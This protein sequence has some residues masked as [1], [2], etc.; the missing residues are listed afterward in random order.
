V[1]V[2]GTPPTAEGI[3]R[4]CR[5]VAE[6]IDIEIATI[7]RRPFESRRIV[8]LFLHVA[9]GTGE[10]QERRGNDVH[11]LSIGDERLGLGRANEAGDMGLARIRCSAPSTANM[12][13][14]ATLA[15]LCS[16]APGSGTDPGSHRPRIDDGNS[17]A[18]DDMGPGPARQGGRRCLPLRASFARRFRRSFAEGNRIGWRRSRPSAQFRGHRHCMRYVI[19][20]A[21]RWPALSIRLSTRSAAARSY[22]AIATFSSPWSPTQ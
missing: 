22:E 20:C 4:G 10:N 1:H 16:R 3:G 11:D 21:L 17:A 14:T 19:R 5:P 6:L 2:A 12:P 7:G 13:F 8:V 18:G 15:V 9:F